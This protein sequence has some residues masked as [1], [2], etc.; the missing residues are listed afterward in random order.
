MKAANDISIFTQRLADAYKDKQV[1]QMNSI[2]IKAFDTCAQLN[3]TKCTKIV[4][5]HSEHTQ[6]VIDGYTIHGT[7]IYNYTTNKF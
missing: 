5:Q 2:E 7:V 4:I 1:L 3:G 6:N